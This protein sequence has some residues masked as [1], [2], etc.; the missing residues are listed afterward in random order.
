MS[1]VLDLQY[2]NIVSNYSSNNIYIKVSN[3][4]TFNTYDKKIYSYDVINYK[5]IETLDDLYKLLSN[6]FDTAKLHT[7]V[8]ITNLTICEQNDN[9]KLNIAYDNIIKFNIIIELNKTIDNVLQ[10]SSDQY[11]NIS[12]EFAKRDTLIKES[13][14]QIKELKNQIIELKDFI[15]IIVSRNESSNK[16]PS[17]CCHRGIIDHVLCNVTH[18]YIGEKSNN[19]FNDELQ[20]VYCLKYSIYDIYTRTFKPF[21][22]LKCLYLNMKDV[23]TINGISNENVEEI[24]LQF[25]N[26]PH[27]EYHKQFI[28]NC[29]KLK[30]IHIY[31]PFNVT[32][33]MKIYDEI[34]YNYPNAHIYI[35]SSDTYLK[36]NTSLK[37]DRIHLMDS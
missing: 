1:I 6:A 20:I 9:L 28:D 19:I 25:N 3:T 16:D 31:N 12:Q 32:I 7:Y 15:K 8:S 29:K 18:L 36:Q 35:T 10:L 5:F 13:Q 22:Y 27:S 2:Y 33:I 4:K 34:K 30:L 26:K 37:L 21:N 11:I 24:Y 14:D 23:H 17:I